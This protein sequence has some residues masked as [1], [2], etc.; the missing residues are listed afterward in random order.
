MEQSYPSV[1]VRKRNGSVQCIGNMEKL[2]VEN[3]EP[4]GTGAS[5]CFYPLIP[6]L[7]P[8]FSLSPGRKGG[9]EGFLGEAT[10]E[11]KSN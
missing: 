8:S 4:E 5:L 10:S 6:P 1:E 3:L 7:L 9:R 2:P 11:G